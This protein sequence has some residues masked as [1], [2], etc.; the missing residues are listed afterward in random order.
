MIIPPE[1]FLTESLRLSSI[2]ADICRVLAE[3]IAYA[4][5]A[6]AIQR[7][8]LLRAS[9]LVIDDDQVAL[10]DF[11]RII[12]LAAGKAALP[13]AS[14]LSGI[15][16]TRLTSGVLIT[17]DGYLDASLALPRSCFMVFEASHPL[18]DQRNLQASAAVM[19]LAQ[20]INPQ[21]LVICLISGG[22]SSLLTKP[23]PDLSLQDIQTLTS[24]LLACGASIDELNTIRKHLD[25]YK[26]GGLA[27]LFF[28]ATLLT[29]ILSD[30]IDDRLDMVASGPTVADPTT[31]TDA[32]LIFEKYQ[33]VDRVPIRIRAHLQDGI[34]GKLH[35]TVKSGDPILDKVRNILVGNNT[36]TVKA[37]LQAAEQL[38]Y[39]SKIITTSLHGEA[40]EVG[41]ILAETAIS[42]LADDSYAQ[43]ACLIAGG[44]TTV[45]IRGSGQGGRNQELALGSVQGLSATQ[46]ELVLVTLAT[47][48]GDGPTDAAGAVVTNHTF[49]RA[50][51]SGF[52]PDDYLQHNDA[53]HY[54]EKIGDL[55]KTGP[56]LTNVNDLALIF[57]P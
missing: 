33:I 55:I 30:V 45:T 56:T 18:P 38:G 10:N 31:Y 4:D 2:G 7:K 23:S 40:S 6:A 22:A 32:W 14:A 53:Y 1:R 24:L 26:G 54:F 42:Y 13:M 12:V 3:T 43:P 9:Q 39:A 19:S 48:G 46:Q 34:D 5:P 8:I 44:E 52:Y 41:Q 57:I 27:R 20:N 21:D 37:A 15:L 29:L 36:Q 47:D 17:K 11:K 35:E 51:A 25:E 50:A 49:S 28:P 16:G